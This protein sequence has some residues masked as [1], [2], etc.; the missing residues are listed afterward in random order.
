MVHG[1]W[2][3]VKNDFEVKKWKKKPKILSF[4]ALGLIFV[5]FIFES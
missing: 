5:V 2:K 4:F 3:S 1:V